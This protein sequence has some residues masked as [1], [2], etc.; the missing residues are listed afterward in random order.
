MAC[1]WVSLFS[2]KEDIYNMEIAIL[3]ILL[4][5]NLITKNELNNAIKKLNKEH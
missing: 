1:L 4:K 5:E 2:F 3:K